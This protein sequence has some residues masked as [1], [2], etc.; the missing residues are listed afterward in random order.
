MMT[1]LREYKDVF[2]RGGHDVR[3]TQAVYH[4]IPLAV[5]TVP[6]RQPT[7]RLGP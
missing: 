5:G 3:L 4:K 2:S 7:R 6:V 1:L